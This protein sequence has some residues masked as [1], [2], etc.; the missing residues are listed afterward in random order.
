MSMTR[1]ADSLRNK[2]SEDAF[3]CMQI[4]QRATERDVEWLSLARKYEVALV[5]S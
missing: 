5:D 4:I 3:V 2:D 1:Y